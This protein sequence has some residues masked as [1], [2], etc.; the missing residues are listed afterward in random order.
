MQKVNHVEVIMKIA[1]RCN[2]D[3]QYCYYFKGGDRAW[4]ARSK[5]MNFEVVARLI[6]YLD[7]AIDEHQ[8]TSIQFDF[9]GGEPLLYGRNNL[10]TL[11]HT[12][13]KHFAGK[14][15]V[16]FA[17]QTNAMLVDD[18]WLRLF[19]KHQINVSISL[20]GPKQHHDA[21]RVDHQG[22]G[23]F[24][25][26]MQGVALLKQAESYGEIPPM[27]LLCVINPKADGQEAYRFFV[28]ELN[29]KH[30]DFL[31]P[32]TFN[33][34]VST[35]EVDGVTQY[36]LAAWRAWLS[37]NNPAIKIR[38]FEA[39]FAALN[40]KQGY[41]FPSNHFKSDVIA[42]TVDADG[43]I[44]GD[45]SLRANLSFKTFKAMNVYQHSFTQF[46]TALNQWYETHIQLPPR[47]QN[48]M[49]AKVCRGGQLEHRYNDRKGFNNPSVYCFA[50]K[51]TFGAVLSFLY[52]SGM[53]ETRIKQLLM[54]GR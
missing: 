46:L 54:T 1:S 7:K 38:F 42:I 24:D 33:E 20:D 14:V 35:S 36:L 34:E 26:A 51:K 11:C 17:L 50:L 41:M 45:D 21:K 12:L 4:S 48:C 19:Q 3:C 18:A 32:S 30:F 31:L 28:D 13:Y 52:Q 29:I 47:C 27:S 10:D 6:K 15:K 5:R 43:K 22:K 49:Y 2:I 23:T 25:R 16:R 39:V 53:P 9:H 37:D 44:S 40:G 8:I